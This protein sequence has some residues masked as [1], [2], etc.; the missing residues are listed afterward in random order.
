MTLKT[1]ENLAAATLHT[2]ILA[3]YV[4]S[5]RRFAPR[6]LSPIPFAFPPSQAKQEVSSDVWAPFSL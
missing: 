4:I 3:T 5:A 2:E 1:K 6:T